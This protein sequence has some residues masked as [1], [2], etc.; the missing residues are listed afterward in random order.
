VS[1]IFA[2][3]RAADLGVTLARDCNARGGKVILVSTDEHTPTPKL[4]PVRIEAVP[5]PWESVTS[6][7]V[8]QALTLAMIEE[9]GANLK[10]RF[11]YGAMYE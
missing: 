8:P 11:E 1:I 7:L 2:L 3:G 5:G 6:I 4:L 10:P 9:G